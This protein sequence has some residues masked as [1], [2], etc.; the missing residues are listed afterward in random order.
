[1]ACGAKRGL[2]NKLMTS[3]KKKKSP[4]QIVIIKRINTSGLSVFKAY[5]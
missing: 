4:K 2:G 5:H 3:L 1:M